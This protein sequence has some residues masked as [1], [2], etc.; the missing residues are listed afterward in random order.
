MNYDHRPHERR[1][2]SRK[3][4]LGC[5]DRSHPIWIPLISSVD[6]IPLRLF[7]VICV[8][9]GSS[10]PANADEYQDTIQPYLKTYCMECHAGA[11]AKGELD[12][13]KFSTSADVIDSFR[14]WKHIIEFIREGEMPP[15]EVRT[16]TWPA[17]FPGNLPSVTLRPSRTDS[18]KASGP[19]IRPAARP[20][21]APRRGARS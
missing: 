12:L 10:F 8:S 9:V 4:S 20:A 1:R 6:V 3:R 15:E 14:R 13:L 19:R 21:A 16:K 2:A 18:A 17:R 11:E 7:F 5:C